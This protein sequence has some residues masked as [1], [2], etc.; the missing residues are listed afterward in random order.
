MVLSHLLSARTQKAP[1]QIHNGH[2]HLVR[3]GVDGSFENKPMA[4]RHLL[5]RGV[6]VLVE[7]HCEGSAIK[8]VNPSSFKTS[9]DM[10]LLLSSVLLSDQYRFVPNIALAAVWVEG[11]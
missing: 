4:Y 2:C 7:L 8:G 9:S 3:L 10:L 1:I 11:W 6:L 5:G